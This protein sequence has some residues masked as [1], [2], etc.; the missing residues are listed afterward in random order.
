MNTKRPSNITLLPLTADEFSI[1][2]LFPCEN[3]S[4]EEND[5]AN[6]SEAS[7]DSSELVDSSGNEVQHITEIYPT[8]KKLNNTD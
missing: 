6:S 3:N 4:S 5:N 8:N 1:I 2:S 7:I